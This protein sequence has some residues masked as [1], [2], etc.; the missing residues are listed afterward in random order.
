MKTITRNLARAFVALGLLGMAIQNA[1][2]GSVDATAS[3][4]SVRFKQ[5]GVLSDGQFR[6]ISGTI[7]YLPTQ[8]QNS[9]GRIEIETASL[10]LGN[11]ATNQEVTKKEWFDSKNYPKGIFI[12]GGLT[13]VGD[14]FKAVG[15]LT[16]KGR[17]QAVAFPVKI[18]L[19]NG[20]HVFT[21]QLPIKRLNFAIGEGEWRDTDILADEVTILFKL[22][23]SAQ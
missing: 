11:A 21:G 5:M 13:P 16:I 18:G 4:I 1:L 17:T 8:L 12:L 3:Q 9:L 15:K 7:D 22:V 23:T 6:K 2:A 10:D 14:A 19:Q 20:R